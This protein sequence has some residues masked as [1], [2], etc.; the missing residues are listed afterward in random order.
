VVRE[1][2]P[3]FARLA[4]LSRGL[5]HSETPAETSSEYAATQGLAA[6]LYGL[7]RAAFE[8]VLTTF[9]LV[10]EEVKRRALRSFDDEVP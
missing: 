8:H 10:P 5:A 9:P 3:A 2:H 6:R 4:A 1:A 7:T